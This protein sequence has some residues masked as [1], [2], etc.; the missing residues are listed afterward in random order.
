[1]LVYF[2][3]YICELKKK[4]L[5]V[6]KVKHGA[7]IAPWVKKGENGNFNTSL[8]AKEVSYAS[9]V[10]HKQVHILMY[11]RQRSALARPRVWICMGNKE[12]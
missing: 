11:C 4:K 6:T 3:I 5:T 9:F 2:T 12:I 1:M 7:I 8:S 10:K